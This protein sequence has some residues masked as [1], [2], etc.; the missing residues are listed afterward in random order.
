LE[1]GE[2]LNPCPELRGIFNQRK[3][4]IK[5]SVPAWV[6][7][8]SSEWSQKHLEWPLD[9]VKNQLLALAAQW[10][11]NS[12]QASHLHR[13]RY[14]EPRQRVVAPFFRVPQ[15]PLPLFLIGD[16]FGQGGVQGAWISGWEAANE[17]LKSAIAI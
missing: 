5:G 7:Q 3:K 11:L 1:S 12:V 4:G 17:L 10:G 2:L 8:A 16:A 15:A 13:W 9:E 14:S 6:V